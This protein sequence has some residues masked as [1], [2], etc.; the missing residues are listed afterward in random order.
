M[1]KAINITTFGPMK[2]LKIA[3]KL[4]DDDI[5][6][7]FKRVDFRLSK[8]EINALFRRPDHKNFREC[9]DQILRNFILGLTKVHRN[10]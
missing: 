1:Y 8:P 7:I 10:V 3:F 4:K 2:K 5:I 6:E 9:G